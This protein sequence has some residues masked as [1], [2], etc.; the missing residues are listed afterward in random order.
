MEQP[1]FVC[2][3]Y[4]KKA[5][6]VCIS[7]G[8]L[9]LYME[10]KERFATAF[11]TLRYMGKARTQVDIAIKM[12]SNKSSISQAMMGNE[13]YLTDNFL[14]RFNR[15]FDGIFNDEWLINGE[16]EM[17]A[18]NNI[19]NQTF[20]RGKNINTGSATHVGDEMSSASTILE[21][22]VKL[23]TEQIGKLIDDNANRGA[24]IDKLIKLLADKL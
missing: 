5:Y 10:K 9:N 11:E 19:V 12:K 17:L 16:G 3:K 1:N 18:P 14:M 23:Q 8:K 13:K 20:N 15:A 24:Q 2:I 6:F 7:Y 4:V 21:E 22:V